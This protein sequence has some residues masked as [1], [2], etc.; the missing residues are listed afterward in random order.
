MR[1]IRSS[2]FIV[3]IA[4]FGILLATACSTKVEVN[5]PYQERA[6]IYALFDLA[7]SIHYVRVGKGFL[8][9]QE[10]NALVAAKNKDSVYYTTDPIKVQLFQELRGTSTLLGTFER[11]AS[12][13]KDTGLFYG[14]DQ[15]LYV[16]RKPRLINLDSAALRQD[17][18][19]SN[20]A[21]RVLRLDVTNMRTGY[22]ATAR[23]KLVY[24]L[25][26]EPFDVGTD[27][28]RLID[29]SFSSDPTFRGRNF[30]AF[31][32]S[33]AFNSHLNGKLFKATIDIPYVE[34]NDNGP[35]DTLMA[36]IEFLPQTFL[37]IDQGDIRK[38]YSSGTENRIFYNSLL[39]QVD[40]N[41]VVAKRTILPIRINI[42]A[43]DSNLSAFTRAN[44]NYSALTQTK[45]YYS[46]VSNGYGLVG[47]R[48][49]KTFQAVVTPE[50]FAFFNERAYQKLRFKAE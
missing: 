48:A 34:F 29:P 1:S 50:S 42:F 49:R 38:R 45:P 30:Y 7:D 44:Q 20:P 4:L 16:L 6:S 33:L 3:Q 21:R 12:T 36:N 46:N 10:G 19:T 25:F 41:K 8:T 40:S 39:N 43:G 22:K 18:R 2:F 23:T 5:A 17:M 35:I 27:S 11:E 13:G 37:D 9:L 26:N 32:P 14:P 28:Y 24:P 47:S 31:S 15:F